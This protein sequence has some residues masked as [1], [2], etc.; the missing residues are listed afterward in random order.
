[1]Q[2]LS[3]GDRELELE[4]GGRH[5]YRK[6]LLA[7]GAWPRHL[8]VPG[9]DLERVF[10]LRTVVNSTDIRTAAGD[11]TRAVVVG[12][13][14]IGMEVAASLRTLGVDVTLVHR[15]QGLYELLQSPE[16][17]QHLAELYRS[18]GVELVLEDEVAAFRGE[19]RLESVETRGG[20][21]IPADLA[22]V[23]IGVEPMIDWLDGSGIEVDNGIV[24][25]ERFETS[26]PDVWAVG[27][28]ANFYD[29]VFE[30]RRRI[31][32]WSNSNYQGSEVGKILAGESGGYDVVSSFFSEVFGFTFRVFGDIP[33]GTQAALRGPIEDGKLLGLYVSD[34]RLVGAVSAGQEEETETRLKEL[35]RSRPVISDEAALRDPEA[36]L[37][38]AL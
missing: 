5:R 4:S 1:V 8:D 14:F 26:A 12:A 21:T 17:S 22:V 25:N 38:E 19:S 33:P 16:I 36:N 30:K 18:K 31:E 6:L 34:G 20:R 29:P 2:S 37:E 7:C 35:I 15:G 23:G 10:T 3:L 32:H 11:A 13:S 9:K 27:D 28:A 24:V